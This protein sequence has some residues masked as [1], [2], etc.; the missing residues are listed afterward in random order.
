M[1]DPE[2]PP[3]IPRRLRATIIIGAFLTGAATGWGIAGVII[4]GGAL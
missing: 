2:N 3:A 4:T 1:D